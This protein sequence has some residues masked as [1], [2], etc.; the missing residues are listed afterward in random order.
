MD[1]EVPNRYRQLYRNS[2]VLQ[3]IRYK[4]AGQGMVLFCIVLYL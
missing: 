4:D 1:F 3:S 2:M